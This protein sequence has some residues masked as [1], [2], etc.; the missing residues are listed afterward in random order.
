M[1]LKKGVLSDL[2]DYRPI[3]LINTD[4]KVFTRILNTCVISWVGSLINP[5]Q[6]GFVRGRFI[7]DNGLLMKLIMEHAHNTSSSAIGLL[8]DQEKTYDRIHPKYLEQVLLRFGFPSVLVDSLLGL[9][10]GT[11]LRLNVNG[12]LS[13]PVP[14]LRGLRQGDPISPVLFNLA[15][16]PFLRGLLSDPSFSGFSQPTTP[17][18]LPVDVSL[19][20]ENVKLLTYADDVLC[21]LNDPSDLDIL[22]FHLHRYSRASNAM[23]NL[24]KTQ[25]LSLA[26][27][28]ISNSPLWSSPLLLHHIDQWHDCKATD[29]LTYLGFP[30]YSP[31]CRNVC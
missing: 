13:E 22:Q 6:T 15:F 25:A 4:N 14:Q 12:F 5:Y 2:R 21:L 30:L 29:P 31:T 7:A 28:P 1:L 20:P 9:F 26:G 17:S 3:S 8:L 16:E 18:H 10:F 19:T 23:V 27:K 24:H 11:S